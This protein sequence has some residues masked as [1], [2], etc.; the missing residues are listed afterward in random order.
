MNSSSTHPNGQGSYI[1]RPAIHVQE[2][3][4][5]V[6]SDNAK[7]NTVPWSIGLF[8]CCSD[9]NICCLSCWCPCI[10]FGRIVDIVDKGNTSST[11]SGAIYTVIAS[12]LG[13]GCLYSYRYR[14]KMREQFHLKE[15]PCGDCCVHF[16]CEN[17]ALAQEYRELEHRGFDM[18]LGWEGNMEKQSHGVQMTL[19]P[20]AFEG[21]MSR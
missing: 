15:S 5:S 9:I 13:C 21:G 14:A 20:P 19:A 18:S 4:S 6:Y 3:S 1:D 12:L 10:L 8:G 17:C 11:A 7:Y 16:C 2:N